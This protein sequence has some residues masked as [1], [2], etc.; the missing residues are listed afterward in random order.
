M[1]KKLQLQIPIPC[2]QNWENMT[3]ADKGRFCASCQKQVIDFSNMSDREIALFFKKPILSLSKDGS[4][5]GRFMEDQLNK[6]IEIPRKRIPWVKY[7][8]QFTLP[9]FLISMKATAQKQREK[10]VKETCTSTVGDIEVKWITEKDTIAALTRSQISTDRFGSLIQEKVSYPA[11]Q[12][13]INKGLIKGKV[14][15]DKGNPVAYATI[16]IK[17]TW[18]GVVAD[19]V[20]KFTLTP[21]SNWENIT[22]SV[23]CVGYVPSETN[24]RKSDFVDNLEIELKQSG[25][26]GEVVVTDTKTH[27]M[28]ALVRCVKSYRT[29]SSIISDV[30]KSNFKIYPNP[31][32]SNSTLKIEWK[33]KEFDNHIFQLFNQTGQL[34][35]TKEMWIDGEARS[36]SINMPSLPSDSYFL[37]ITSVKTGKSYTEKLIIK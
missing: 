10:I 30:S 35:F 2:H 1:P 25:S 36:L 22:L 33:Q 13:I 17:G 15:D 3:R 27:R 12:Q 34:V 24:F 31:V 20:G 29:S 16:V 21:K 18:N 26:L 11:K 14:I 6:E 28:G 37:K 8:F 9:A 19:S 4:V 7:F 32:Q 23:S 5:C